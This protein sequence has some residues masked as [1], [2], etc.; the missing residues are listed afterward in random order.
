MGPG[1]YHL[2][3]AAGYR[4]QLNYT[5]VGFSALAQGKML[6]AT[7]PVM[8]GVLLVLT[9]T[10]SATLGPL[11]RPSADV[12]GGSPGG[13]HRARGVRAK[14]GSGVCEDLVSDVRVGV[15]VV[16]AGSSVGVRFGGKA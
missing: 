4:I 12:P 7:H 9:K 8:L 10:C 6:H 3:L 11:R 14:R 15:R 1:G 2:L 5:A 13:N 16:R